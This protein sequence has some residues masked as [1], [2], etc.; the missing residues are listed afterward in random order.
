[1]NGMMVSG[2]QNGSTVTCGQ[3]RPRYVQYVKTLTGV[4]KSEAGL[5]KERDREKDMKAKCSE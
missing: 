1:M 5:P 3:L 2:L 4:E